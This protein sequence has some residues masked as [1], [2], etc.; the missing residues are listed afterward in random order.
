MCLF[1]TVK[2]HFTFALSGTKRKQINLKGDVFMNKKLFSLICVVTL[3]FSL[4]GNVVYAD[5]TL[6]GLTAEQ[7]NFSVVGTY[8]D[9]TAPLGWTNTGSSF[10]M[11]TDGAEKNF[12]EINYVTGQHGKTVSDRS[13]SYK[14]KGIDNYIWTD[15]KLNQGFNDSQKHC[16][17]EFS[18]LAKNMTANKDFVVKVNN[19][20]AFATTSPSKKY[21]G[22]VRFSSDGYVWVAK[23][24]ATDDAGTIID[25]AKTNFKYDV[26]KWYHVAVAYQN[27]SQDVA[28]YINGTKITA[29]NWTMLSTKCASVGGMKIKPA[30]TSGNQFMIDDIKMYLS[31]E[32]YNP[33]IAQAELVS[34]N[35]AIYDSEAGEISEIPD[36]TTVAGLKSMISVSENATLAV[37]KEG[38]VQS[39]DTLVTSEMQA[40]ITAADGMTLNCIELSVV[41][42]IPDDA[43]VIFGGED[44]SFDDSEAVYA[45]NTDPSGWAGPFKYNEKNKEGETTNYLEY[46]NGVG[47]KAADDRS[48]FLSTITMD[49][50]IKH[51]TADRIKVSKKYYVAEFNVMPASENGYKRVV[52]KVNGSEGFA[53]SGSW[54]ATVG[55][56]NGYVY[57]AKPGVTTDGYTNTWKSD[58]TYETGRWYH[59]AVVYE[60]GGTKA[61]VYINGETVTCDQEMLGLKLTDVGGIKLELP[62]NSGGENSCYI[63]DVR[64]Y[65]TDQVFN[66]NRAKSSVLNTG[67]C[68][69]NESQK[70]ISNI[71]KNATVNELL[72]DIDLYLGATAKVYDSSKNEVTN[73]S[74]VLDGSM[75][76]VVTAANGVGIT[77]YDLDI[78]EVLVPV[79]YNGTPENIVTE[80]TSLNAGDTVFVK[81][82]LGDA[83][84][85]IILVLYDGN[86]LVKIS[87]SDEISAQ[88]LTTSL[89][90]PNDVEIENCSIKAF[91]WED[92]TSLSPL[93]KAGELLK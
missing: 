80:I 93:V 5:T 61:S 27:G 58:Y 30:K 52:V 68:T 49:A 40:V 67:T 42:S 24:G 33:S 29:D 32:T 92:M 45:D 10:G 74:T 39:E 36:V 11:I 12:S 63:D 44:G 59:V 4:I 88:S 41:G 69:V 64:L 37:L 50:N 26:N 18:V 78:P 28:V 9:N 2:R 7:G 51:Y 55:F 46:K 83:T 19:T 8:V 87:K 82:F 20:E 77:A 21:P 73:G 14:T 6:V 71:P 90:I 57:V 86:Q 47:Y 3:L 25:M 16:I 35:G 38:V 43:N 60:V 62:K 79:F 81:T 23:L 1:I 31:S 89:V 22:T 34:I 48:L 72:D 17:V 70:V 85:V 66:P 53:G 65:E 91:L 15:S 13:M 56:Q 84:G 75:K 76:L 54:P